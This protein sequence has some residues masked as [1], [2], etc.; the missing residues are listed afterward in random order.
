MKALE[1]ANAH[2]RKAVQLDRKL[3]QGHAQLGYVLA[4]M[5]EHE[6]Y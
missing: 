1:K 6:F 3:P 4:F 2:A 5:G